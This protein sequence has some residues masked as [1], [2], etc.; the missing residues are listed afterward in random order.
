VFQRST[1]NITIA[2]ERYSEMFVVVRVSGKIG[3]LR[4]LTVADFAL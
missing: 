3:M 1:L 4:R 2:L